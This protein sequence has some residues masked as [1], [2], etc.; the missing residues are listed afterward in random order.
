MEKKLYVC[1]RCGRK[2]M[3]RSHGLCQACRSKELTPKKKN[4]ITSIKNSSKKK[5]LENPDLSGFFRLML[6]ELNESKMSMTGASIH[7][8]TVC[9][10]CHILPKRTYVSV[11][12]ERDNII[13]LTLDEH[14]MFDSY[15]DCLDFEKLESV[16]PFIWKYAVKKVIYMYESGMVEEKGNILLSILERYSKQNG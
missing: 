8:P 4:R 10:V 15:L 2:V 11:A 12:T 9:N 13:F 3:I 6:E 5:K 14:T 1:K 16:F 7:N